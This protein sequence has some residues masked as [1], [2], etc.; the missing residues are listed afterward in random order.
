MPRRKILEPLYSTLHYLRFDMQQDY[1]H[2]KWFLDPSGPYSPGPAPRG[3][4]KI[5]IC[6]PPVLIHRAIACE[7]FEILA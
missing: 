6:V 2:T 1:I 4:I 3:Y 5:P 7:S